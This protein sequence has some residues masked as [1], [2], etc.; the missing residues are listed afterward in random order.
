[1]YET[2]TTLTVKFI[3]ISFVHACVCEQEK[4]QS[5][6]WESTDLSSDISNRKLILAKIEEEIQNAEEVGY[7]SKN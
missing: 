3:F 2:S 7:M 5:V 1:M 6:T 4:L